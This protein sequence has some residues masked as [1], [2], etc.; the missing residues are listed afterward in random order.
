MKNSILSIL[1]LLLCG[2]FTAFSQVDS[3]KTRQLT[4]VAE[5]GIERMQQKY[6]DENKRKPEMAGYRVQIYNGSKQETLKKRT[7]F[8]SVFPGT[9][10]Y[11]TYEAPE[12]RV[13][14]GDFR[15]RLEAEKFLN[16]VVAEFGSGF[17]V[18]TTIKLP[19]LE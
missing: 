16:K 10:V 19:P 2:G 12:Y 7:E 6:I 4:V 1:P 14:A 3:L 11:T 18:K 17:V 15:T 9:A 8:L 5:P 13:Q